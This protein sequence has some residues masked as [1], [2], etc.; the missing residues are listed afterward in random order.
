MTT[1]YIQPITSIVE[2]KLLVGDCVYMCSK[3]ATRSNKIITQN[4]NNF[5]IQHQLYPMFPLKIMKI[6]TLHIGIWIVRNE[7]ERNIV[8]LQIQSK[9]YILYNEK[10]LSW[11]QTHAIYSYSYLTWKQNNINHKPRAVQI[12]GPWPRFSPTCQ[13]YCILS[14]IF[15]LKQTYIDPH[16]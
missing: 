3:I 13:S 16:F 4:Q 15:T 14:T 1:L 11:K 5:A 12:N 9:Y 6:N 8:V 2:T 10:R 7:Y